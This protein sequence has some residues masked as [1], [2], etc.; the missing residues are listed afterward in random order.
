MIDLDLLLYDNET[1]EQPKKDEKDDR[2]LRV[3]H[4]GINE[5]EFVLRPLVE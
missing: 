1:F 3:P 4:Q 5:R 2:W